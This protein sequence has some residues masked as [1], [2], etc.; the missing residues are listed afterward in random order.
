MNQT[1]ILLG[2]NEGDKLLHLRR[3]L[4][5]IKNLGQLQKVSSIYQTAAWGLEEQDSFLNQ[6]IELH[7]LLSPE[8]LLTSLL[9][10]EEKMG[11]KRR[12]KWASRLI[13]IDILYIGQGV[14]QTER[15][16][17]PH[18]YLHLRRFTLVPLCEIAKDFRHP[19][20]LKTNWEL[21]EECPDTLAVEVFG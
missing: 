8:S 16:Q 12:A 5:A 15:L 20:Y 1:Y 6:V 10:I 18:P 4:E 9:D 2:S 13:D 17:V 21:L 3:A 7:T 14:I 19:I 11:R